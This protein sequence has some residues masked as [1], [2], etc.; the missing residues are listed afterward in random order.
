MMGTKSLRGSPTALAAL[1]A[2][3]V[4][5]AS[6]LAHA[7]TYDDRSYQGAVREAVAEYDLG[8]FPE[9]LALFE[10]A[11][12]LSPNA[13]TLRGAGMSAFA[14]RKYVLALGYLTQSLENENKPLTP[15]M[16]MEVE[17][18]IT[19]ANTFVVNYRVQLEPANAMLLVDGTAVTLPDGQLTVD[20]GEH[21]IVINAEG[22]EPLT[23]RLHAETGK[24]ELLTFALHP[25]AADE[26]PNFFAQRKWTWVALGSAAA[27]GAAAGV[28]WW[29]AND[30]L[31]DVVD[32]CKALPMGGCTNKQRDARIDHRPISTYELLTDVSLGLAGAALVT[33]GVL[34]WSEAP[35]RLTERPSESEASVELSFTPRSIALRGRF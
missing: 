17:D 26:G 13:R 6:P 15:A 20:P 34:L 5:F 10:R 18:L 14:M 11:H 7:Q 27:F 19:R 21:E 30:K 3:L 35:R 31:N 29:Q 32:S 4:A 22:Y 12:G 9:A 2:L 16:R 1:I 8:N 24:A 33:T 25:V 23:R 28:F